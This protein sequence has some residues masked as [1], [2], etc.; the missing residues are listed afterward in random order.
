MTASDH[1]GWMDADAPWP[2]GVRAGCTLRTGG[3]S[4]PPWDSFNLGDHVGDSPDHVIQNRNR[5]RAMW[6]IDMP[7]LVQVHGSSVC[8]LEPGTEARPVADAAWTDAPGTAA[9]VLVADCLPVLVA[10]ADGRCVAAAHAGWRGLAG[11]HGRGILEA[12]SESLQSDAGQVDLAGACV[13]LGP[14]IGPQAFEVG[15]EV[16]EAF[17]VSDPGALAHFEAVP[18]LTGPPKF[19]AGLAA[20]ARRR[21]QRLGFQRIHGND[22]SPG[23]CTHQQASRFFSHRRDSVSLGATGRMAALIWRDSGQ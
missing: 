2:P 17:T 13:W 7:F 9:V 5:L 8:R 21:L 15:Q 4:L 6:G 16:V 18:G 1:T 20:L 22:G 23:W 19:M 12:L 10:S 3:D 11:Q 14:C